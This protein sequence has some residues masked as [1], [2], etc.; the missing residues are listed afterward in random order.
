MKFNIETKITE[1]NSSKAIKYLFETENITH[2][3]IIIYQLNNYIKNTKVLLNLRNY[4]YKNS[5]K[6]KS[7]PYSLD[8]CG[9]EGDDIIINLFFVS[10]FT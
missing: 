7:V 1:K 8:T 2:Q 3:S 5:N 4:I 6:I 9:T 10:V